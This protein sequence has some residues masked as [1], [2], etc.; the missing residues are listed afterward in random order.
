MKLHQLRDNPGANHRC[1]RVG[2]GPGSGTG[3]TAGR[4]A[5][6]QKSRSGVALGGFEGGQMPLY[7]RMPKRGFRNI[8]RKRYAVVG[9]GQ[10]QTFIDSGRIDGSNLIDETAILASGL[11]G[12]LHDGVRI[13]ANGAISSKVEIAVSGASQAAV[14]QVEAAGGSLNT[15]TVKKTTAPAE[16]GAESN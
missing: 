5:K 4:G 6:G 12:R 1:K 10:L 16:S 15:K 8:N 7:Q 13:L 9:L 14:A 11:V 2:R 3:K